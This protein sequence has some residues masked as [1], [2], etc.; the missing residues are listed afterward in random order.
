[1][2]T[3]WWFALPVI[4]RY[5]YTDPSGMA[6]NAARSRPPSSSWSATAELGF[7][8]PVIRMRPTA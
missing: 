3:S 4:P 5:R 7:Q 1:M 8:R 6:I 2:T